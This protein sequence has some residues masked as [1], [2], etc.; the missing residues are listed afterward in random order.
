MIEQRSDGTLF[1]LDRIWVPLKG[2]V[3]T[4]IMDEAHKSKYAVH[5]GADKM[6]YDLRDMTSSGYGTIWVIIDWLI[7]SAHFLPMREDY[8]MD[9]LAR[10]YLNEIVARHGKLAP[11]FVGPVKIIEKVGR[12]AY[13]LDLP[14]EL[15]GVHDTFHVSNLKKCLA[16]PT[17]QVPLDEIQVDAKLD[18]VE[19][20]VEILEREFKKLKRSRIAI[21]KFIHILYS[22]DD[23][24]FVE[25]CAG[26]R[27]PEGQW[28]AYERKDFQDSPDDEKDTRSSHEYLN[29]LEEEYQARSLLAKSKRF[30]KKGTQRF[31]S[32]KAA[33]QTECHKCGKKGHFTRN[34]WSKTSVPSYQSPFQPK[35]LHSSKHKPEPRRLNAETYDW[36][37]EEVSS[38]DDEVIE[39]K[40]LMVLTDEE[41]VSVGKESANN[42]ECVKI[43]IQKHVNTEILK[44]NQNLRNELK[45][46]TSI[47]EAWPKS[48]NKVNQC[49]SEQIH[50][51]K[52][53]ILGIDQLTEDTSSSRPKDSVFMK[54]LADNSKISIT[55]KPKLSGA[56]DFT[57]SSHDTGKVPLNESQRN[58]IDHSVII[59]DSLVTDY[60]SA[61]QSSVYSTLLPPLEKLTGITINE[62]SSAPVKGNKSSSASKTNSAPAGKLKNVKIE[63]DL[64][65][66]IIILVKVNPPQDP[67]LQGPQHLFLPAYTANTMIII[68]TIVYTIP[69]VKYVE[70]MIMTLMNCKTCG[71]NVHTTSDHNDIEWF[72]KIETLQAKNAESFKASKNESSSALRSKTPTK[73]LGLQYPK[74]SGFDYKGYSDSD[75]VECDMNRKSTSSTCL[76]LKKASLVDKVA[77]FSAETKDIADA[78]CCAN[79]LWI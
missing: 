59:S 4:L 78:G 3:K 13:R 53:K 71:S 34:R 38:N 67:D 20:P 48:S 65:L 70:A 27:K 49:I 1:Y 15:D 28:T 7:K 22:V 16:D 79:I 30:F 45:E 19:E 23:G 8:K 47:T 41:R 36:D 12:V 5:P 33:N 25:N 63:D 56:E 62:P 58:I 66:A 35:L 18:F 52:K 64:P 54:S 51:Q 75:Y 44:E 39:V 11:R 73:S 57:L 24:D 31:S 37:E 61:D 10:L 69:H 76:L 74:L 9:R 40:A 77:M 26:Q 72:R 50:T 43:S 14:E 32:A 60:N 6:Y 2:D 29:D 68:L 46:L 55:G 17:L 42:G 21:V